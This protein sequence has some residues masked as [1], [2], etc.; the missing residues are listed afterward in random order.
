MIRVLHIVSSLS[1]NAGIINMIMQYYR[2]ID[3]EKI[4]FDFLYFKGASDTETYK[5]EISSLGGYYYFMPKLSL[6]NIQDVN[7]C[8]DKVYEKY[9][10]KTVHCHEAILVNFIQR[11]LRKCGM[12]KLLVHSHSLC[13]SNTL[14]GRIRNRLMVTGINRFCDKMLA[15]SEAAGCYLFGKKTF[16]EKGTVLLNGVDT[17]QYIYD[18]ASRNMIREKLGIGN[19]QF[20]IGTVGRCEKLKN[21]EYILNILKSREINQKNIGFLLVGDGP[22]L[23]KLKESAK[24]SG[25]LQNCFFVGNKK[26]V[27]PYLCAMDVFLF[28]SIS[29]GFGVALVEAQLCQLFSIASNKV[30]RETRIMDDTLYYDI[31]NQACNQWIDAILSQCGSEKEERKKKVVNR[32]SVDIRN[33]VSKLSK[34]YFCEGD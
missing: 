17:S 27:V 6:T 3:R 14:K 13:L 4:Q 19:E 29:E 23:E 7:E 24:S 31:D 21:H 12:E 22:L 5:D 15:C 1:V 8:L 25:V 20:I 10:Y 16:L 9:D 32:N 26:D 28:P 18:E 33:C 11:K 2:F 30:P 34:I